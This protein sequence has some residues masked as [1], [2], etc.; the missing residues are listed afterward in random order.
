MANAAFARTGAARKCS[1]SIKNIA[2]LSIISVLS[3]VDIDESKEDSLDF[4]DDFLSQI[5]DYF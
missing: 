2:K 4:A 1:D 3:L 5:Y